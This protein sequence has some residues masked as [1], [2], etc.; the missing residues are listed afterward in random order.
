[1][2]STKNIILIILVAGALLAVKF[3]FFPGKKKEMKGPGPGQSQGP[4]IVS[5]TVVKPQ[6]LDKRIFITGTLLANNEVKLMPER[7]GKVTGIFFKEGTKVTKGQLLLKLNDAVMQAQLKKLKLQEQLATDKEGRLKKLL[8]IS[9]ISQ[10]DYDASLTELNA[11]KADIELLQAQINETQILA[12]FN[13]I[14]GL[15]TITE[16]SYVTPATEVTSIRQTDPLKLDFYIPERYADQVS[17]GDSI[18]FTSENSDRKH[19]AVISA[20]EPNVDATTQTLQVRALAKNPDGRNIPG[21]IV[22]IDLALSKNDSA[23]LI[24]TESVITIMKAKKVFV[25][26]N[27]KAEEATIKAGVRTESH[28]QVVD[29]L[30][31]GDTVI[32]SGIMQLKKGSPVKITSIR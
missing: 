26:R 2:K 5:A 9:G 6:Q 11:L 13:G 19:A 28:L 15:T 24:P 8:A 23:L 29:G 25:V 12:P 20:I 7:A 21:A 22:K 10:Q 31:K 16:G 14:I 30:K 27:G 3:I 1:M 18:Y 4:V 17:L 32:T